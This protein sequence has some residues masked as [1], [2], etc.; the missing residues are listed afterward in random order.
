[1]N[2]AKRRVIS[3]ILSIVITLGMAIP[4]CIGVSSETGEITDN[5]ESTSSTEGIKMLKSYNAKDGIL[6]LQAYVTGESVIRRERKAKPIDIVLV[7]DA[8]D[9]MTWDCDL[10][11]TFEQLQDLDKRDAYVKK[12]TYKRFALDVA[13]G[14]VRW[15]SSS[16]I[17]EFKNVLGKWKTI[18]E[19]DS[20]HYIYCKRIDALKFSA[21]KFIKTIADSNPMTRIGLVIFGG[22]TSEDKKKDEKTERYGESQVVQE[23]TSCTESGK[24]SLLTAL[25]GIDVTFASTAQSTG[26]YRGL[27]LF[28]K[29]LSEEEKD[30]LNEPEVR[31]KVMV[32]FTD[33]DPVDED[34]DDGI[35]AAKTVKDSGV[36]LYTIGLFDSETGDAANYAKYMSSKYPNAQSMTNHGSAVDGTYSY[37]VSKSASLSSILEWISNTLV[38][39]T[40]MF[41]DLD[42]RTT[43]RDVIS[44]EFELTEGKTDGIHVYISKYIGKDTW[45]TPEPYTN[46]YDADEIKVE[47][48]E[49]SKTVDV[50]GFDYSA[51][52]C[53]EEKS[54]DGVTYHGQKIIVTIPINPTSTAQGATGINTNASGSGI[55]SPDGKPVNDFPPPT[56]DLPTNIKVTKKFEG[57]VPD[58]AEFT[59]GVSVSAYITGYENP[60]EDNYTKALT[61]SKT[62]DDFVLSKTKSSDEVKGILVAGKD[63]A[64][65]VT[66]TER[67]VPAGYKVTFSDGTNSYEYDGNGGDVVSPAFTVT[68][69]MEITI[70]NNKLYPDACKVTLENEVTG[71][72][73]DKNADF[74]FTGSYMSSSAEQQISQALKH[75]ASKD[76]EIVDFGSTFIVS[77]TNSDG[78]STSVYLNGQPLEPQDGVYKFTVNGDTTVKFV[79][80]KSGSVE[81]GLQMDFL[82][83]VLILA[84]V[85]A[86]AVAFIIRRKKANSD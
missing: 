57:Y 54:D 67:A 64:S 55:V 56:T 30:K 24:E 45:S 5:K 14:E 85:V 15:N 33:G 74:M 80:D 75:G 21:E 63:R 13:G 35:D 42:K 44:Q 73:G 18:E 61:D 71:D 72:Y 62:F 27:P 52:W 22:T 86:G 77:A 46:Y 84:V 40:I 79:H 7:L 47:Y 8:T 39:E 81:T 34:F 9:S 16:N 60:D 4:L 82:P 19:M 76:Y 26:L 23:L 37:L 20:N 28:S 31:D 29:P 58:N 3:V 10:A 11:T 2:S 32:M 17:W 25:S 78:Y 41:E 51:N 65:T 59:V 49:K 50:T 36:I 43:L 68:P 53:G 6:T 38:E 66:V 70:T 1:M 12:Y 48:Y 83:Y 69:D